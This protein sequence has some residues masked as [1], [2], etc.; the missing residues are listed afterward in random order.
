LAEDSHVG[1]Q[2]KRERAAIEK[3]KGD[4]RKKYLLFCVMMMR[5]TSTGKQNKISGM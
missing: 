2:Q 4:Q 1:S 5:N 3:M